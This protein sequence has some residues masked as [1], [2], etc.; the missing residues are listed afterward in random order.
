MTR[1]R[2]VARIADAGSDRNLR[3]DARPS[4]QAVWDPASTDA[5]HE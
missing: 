5:S 1:V 2:I 4:F 3:I